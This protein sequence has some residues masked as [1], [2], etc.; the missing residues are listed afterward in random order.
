[1]WKLNNKVKCS[2]TLLLNIRLK[3]KLNFDNQPLH[4]HAILCFDLQY[5]DG[6]NISH[7][8]GSSMNRKTNNLVSLSLLDN[9]FSTPPTYYTLCFWEFEQLPAIC[10]LL[11]HS[12]SGSHY[13]FYY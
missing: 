2:T 12:T 4:L 13:C 5:R 9:G 1:M 3:T 10:V 6:Q 7:P 8:P 11:A